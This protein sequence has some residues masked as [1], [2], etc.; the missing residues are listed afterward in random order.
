MQITYLTEQQESKF[1]LWKAKTKYETSSFLPD[2]Y[3]FSWDGN[4]Q[5]FKLGFKFLITITFE[6][7]S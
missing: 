5:S 2:D 6:L 4:Y 1:K 7:I 3:L